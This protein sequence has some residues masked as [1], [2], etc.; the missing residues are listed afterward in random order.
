MN[1]FLESEKHWNR[2]FR[3]G[4]S[5]IKRKIT[6]QKP[7]ETNMYCSEY[8]SRKLHIYIEEYFILEA[9]VWSKN[10]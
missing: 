7:R 1:I 6:F 3:D 8:V 5:G 10:K 4:F 2:K 9:L